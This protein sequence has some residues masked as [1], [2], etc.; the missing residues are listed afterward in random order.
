MPQPNPHAHPHPILTLPDLHSLQQPQPHLD[1]LCAALHSPLD[2]TVCGLMRNSILN[3]CQKMFITILVSLLHAMTCMVGAYMQVTAAFCDA[4]WLHALHAP[5]PPPPPPPHPP[6]LTQPPPRMQ[7]FVRLAKWEDRGYYAMKVSTER[8]QRQ[9]H[10]LTRR[11]QEA[12]SH[13]AAAVLAAA[14]KAMGFADLADADLVHE[15]KPKQNDARAKKSR[16]WE[17]QDVF[18]PEQ[19]SW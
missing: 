16:L 11:A 18:S 3:Q 2:S 13:P 19:A 6:P 10:R 9:L 7:D 4:T 8:N 17:E 14:S 5:P 12:L 15:C 1:R